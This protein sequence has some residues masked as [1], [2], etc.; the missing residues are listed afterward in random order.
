[1]TFVLIGLAI[2]TLAL[3]V[4]FS[5]LLMWIII[6]CYISAKIDKDTK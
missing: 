6:G 4:L 3:A 2:L 5:P 1:M